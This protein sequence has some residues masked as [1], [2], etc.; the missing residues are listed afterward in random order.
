MTWYCLFSSWQTT[1]LTAGT[2]EMDWQIIGHD[3]A[4]RLLQRGLATG[5]MSHAYLISGPAQ[6]GK[7]TLALAWA[8]ALNCSHDTPPCGRCS[9]CLKA[10][11]N[12]HPDIQTIVG[13][14]AGGSI[15]IE[16][17][18]TMQREAVLAPYEGRFRVL[19]LEEMDRASTEAANCLLK[20]LEEP[21]GHVVLI[22]TAIH[23]EALPDTV[24]SR[25]QQLNLRPVARHLIEEALVE[26]GVSRPQAGLFAQLSGGRVGW[27]LEAARDETLRR[28]RQQD[29]DQLQ[30]LLVAD[31]VARFEFASTAG[32]DPLAV[33]R[34]IEQW[35]TW[36]RDLL[37]LTSSGPPTAT[38]GSMH[39]VNTDRIDELRK[40]AH[41]VTP[42]QACAALKAL[43]VAVDRLEANVNPQL[44]LEGLLLKLPGRPAS[45]KAL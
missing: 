44:A 32:R 38:G 36:W 33:R 6:I 45:Y 12:S 39:V 35:S 31:P 19:I 41:R 37:L 34:R 29:L 2:I 8:Q 23:T 20:T 7:T 22:L 3:W 16:Q 25:C 27:A 11:R 15:K 43:H 5:R 28:Q 4:V 18:R 21:P 17:I 13:Q 14:G 40:M 26:R 24:V 10:A 1:E 9:S 30:E 42:A